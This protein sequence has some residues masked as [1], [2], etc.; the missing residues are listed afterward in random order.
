[1]AKRKWNEV[2]DRATT[3][4][5]SGE[6]VYL[7]GSKNVR[8]TSEAQIRAYFAETVFWSGTSCGEADTR[9]SW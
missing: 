6:Y 2:V 5:R 3:A 7:Y 4:F 9:R 8:L 1:M